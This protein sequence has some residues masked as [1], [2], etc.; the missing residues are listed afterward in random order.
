ME[1]SEARTHGERRSKAGRMQTQKMGATSQGAKDELG[2]PLISDPMA[3][4]QE[5]R[6]VA[7]SCPASAL[8]SFLLC[9][10][11]PAHCSGHRVPPHFEHSWRLMSDPSSLAR[12]ERL[13]RFLAAP[14]TA[15]AWP[16]LGLSPS[17]LL[18]S[19]PSITC[20]S[21]PSLLLTRK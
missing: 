13:S 7:W 1:H 6:Q 21:V 19:Y 9:F 5:H 11:P 10:C 17:L 14:A 12:R 3:L 15:E 4:P 20:D 16:G 18:R 8:S 2:A